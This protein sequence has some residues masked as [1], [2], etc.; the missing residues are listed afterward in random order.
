MSGDRFGVTAEESGFQS[1]MRLNLFLSSPQT[2][3]GQPQMPTGLR[4]RNPDLNA[5]GSSRSL[6]MF[7]IHT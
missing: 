3:K 4:P 1:G 6:L 5:Q 2:R 7:E